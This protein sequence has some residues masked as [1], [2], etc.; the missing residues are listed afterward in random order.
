MSGKTADLEPHDPQPILIR[1]PAQVSPE[2]LERAQR[3]AQTCVQLH[4]ALLET[5]HGGKTVLFQRFA[6]ELEC[7][8]IQMRRYYDQWREHKNAV[9]LA[10]KRRRDAGQARIPTALLELV[11]SV[12]ITNPRANP[13][14]VRRIIELAN[15]SSLH[16][17]ASSN[18]RTRQTLS[19]SSISRIRSMLEAD[20]IKRFAFY[21]G[22]QRRE[23]MRH[24]AG[25]V[26]AQH[27]TELYEADMTRCDQVVFNP[28]MGKAERLRIHAT[29]DIFSGAIPSMVF[30]SLEN[31]QQTDR[32][33]LLALMEKPQEW[34]Q[35]WPVYGTPQKIYW[36]NGK[37][38][39]SSRSHAAL[40][41]FGIEVIHSDHN[42]L[43]VREF[44]RLADKLKLLKT[45]GSDFH[46]T[47]KPRIGIGTA[48][49]PANP[50]GMVRCVGGGD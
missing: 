3:I 40:E 5:R 25:E 31:Q 46:G 50:A 24:W 12:C 17:F 42:D 2:E 49:R 47:N 45:G 39:R 22:K 13:R 4:A 11:E 9:S 43:E 27:A 36:D 7:S 35:L 18:S 8:A 34:A 21:D 23:F 19:L 32:M 16:Y 48:E 29:I 44:E 15:P 33:I 1:D 26:M 10:R 41:T 30:S 6:A 28:E 20:P 14:R 37:T 38:Y